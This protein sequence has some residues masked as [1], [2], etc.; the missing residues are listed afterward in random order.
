MILTLKKFKQQ[1]LLAPFPG[2]RLT[3]AS[4]LSA[5]LRVPRKGQVLEFQTVIFLPLWGKDVRWTEKG[6][7]KTPVY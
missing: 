6:L 4:R 1:N 7:L 3:C 5:L 2:L